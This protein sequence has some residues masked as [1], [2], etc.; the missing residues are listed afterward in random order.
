MPSEVLDTFVDLSGW[1]TV[2]SGRARLQ[3]S[4]ADG[5]GGQALQLDFDFA[6]GGGFVVAR[7]PFSLLLPE[8]YTFCFYVRGVAPRNRLEFKLIDVQGDNVWWSCQDAFA[9]PADW[10]PMRIS[11]R[12]IA[13][14]WG[15]AGGGT[16]SHVGAIELVIAAGSGGK[17]TVWISDLR[18]EDRSFRATPVVSASSAQTGHAPQ[19]VV[20]HDPHTRWRSAASAMPQW[21][22]IDFRQEREYGGVII[23]WE[24]GRQARAFNVQ[25]STDGTHWETV[26][27]ARRAAGER[28]YVYVPGTV[29]R[30]VQLHFFRGHDPAGYGIIAIDIQPDDFSRSLNAF[31]QHVARIEAKGLYPKYWLGEQTY[32]SPIGL[33]DAGAGQ[34]LLNE[35]GMLE[36]D[37]GRFCIEPFVFVDGALITW[38]DTAPVPTLEQGYLPMPSSLWP[39]D[40]IR[41]TTTVC[42]AEGTA[43]PVIYVRYRMENT[44]MTPRQGRV[45]AALRPLQVTPPWQAFRSF[46]GVAPIRTLAYRAGLV[47]VNDSQVV[48]P[49]T[50]PSQFA[51]VA[52][53][54]GAITAYLPTGELPAQTEVNDD[55][56]YAS[57]ALQYDFEVAPGSTREVYLAVPFAG[58][59]GAMER[60]AAPRLTTADAAKAFETAARAWATRLGHVQISL[61]PGFRSY[62]D[63]LHTAIAHILINRDGPALQPGPRRYSRS[64]IRD[65]AI[66]AAALLRLG[67][68]DAVRD[69]VRWYA[70]YQ[71]A[72]GNVPAIVDHTGPDW[73]AEHDSHGEFIY[74]VMEYFR[75]TGDAAFLSDMWPAVLK[76]VAYIDT[77]RRQRLT[78]AFETPE[79]R[80]CYGLLPESVSHEGYLA[81][82]V[83][84]YW[85]DF[86][87]LRGLKD[88]LAMAEALGDDAQIPRLAALR[89]AFRDTLYP[90]I[91]ATMA[92]H[93][94]DYIPGSVEWADP[95]AAATAIAVTLVDEGHHLPAAALAHTFAHYLEHARLRRRG[96]V[97]WTNYTPYEMRII[98]ALVRLGQRQEAHELL[99]FFMA[100]RRPL[101]WNQWPE[102][103]WRDPQSPA[104]IGDLPHAWI[105]AEYALAWLSLCAFEREADGALVIAAGVSEAWVHGA[106]GMS[107]RGLPTYYGTLNYTLR[108]AGPETFRLT[109][110]GNL[111][112]PP[113]GIIAKPPLP[114]PVV[115]VEINGHE[116]PVFDT[117]SVRIGQCPAEVVVHVSRNL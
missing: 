69:F 26:Y 70:P 45:F 102:I 41:F 96:K 51:A 88:A 80:A 109:L 77:L 59:D 65:G 67:C 94:I 116:Q 93:H 52:F 108:R 9:F 86:W 15:P 10:Q 49:L 19:H 50:T 101:A 1:T 42:A 17:G 72:D 37:R 90:S 31:F 43:T 106:D 98:G 74:C 21:L 83:H 104:H 13:F 32:W 82:P 16:L 30:Y 29:S 2:A 40:G 11:H 97:D 92:E 35:E 54:Q 55:F 103:A 87:A 63:T 113:G 25:T 56:G 5:V 73:L 7:K 28:S 89:D 58:G 14:A 44:G 46:G 23:H 79:K 71:A 115:R 18:L 24:P 39:L 105:G 99:A 48:I 6:G 20:D 81:H 112:I 3:L 85:D 91:R 8:A 62:V 84:A 117:D 95:D 78:P 110:T 111:A 64:W 75:F 4:Q 60:R 33:V 36:A 107:V 68:S 12:E 66:M 22:C 38:A 34:A 57:G 100:D 61:P 76:A 47:W 114:G 27:T 53:E